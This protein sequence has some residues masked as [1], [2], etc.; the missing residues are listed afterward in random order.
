MADGTTTV[1]L[2]A[3]PLITSDAA[4]LE[5]DI[6]PRA[7][8]QPSFILRSDPTA[9][10]PVTTVGLAATG[11]VWRIMVAAPAIVPPNWKDSFISISRT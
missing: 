1:F 7:L 2:E 6:I 9:L 5:S 4:A 3:S 8:W 10:L 11:D